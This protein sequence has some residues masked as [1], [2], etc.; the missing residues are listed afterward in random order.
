MLQICPKAKVVA[1]MVALKF[2]S[3]Q[4]G[5]EFPQI[6]AK[7]GDIID[8]GDKHLTII[9]APNLHWPD[10]TYTYLQE[11]QILF[12]CDSFGAH[13]CHEAMYDDLVGDY[14]DAFQYY[15]DVILKP[16]SSHFL[17][18]IDKIRDLPI[19]TICTGHG[20]I[21]RTYS[22]NIVAKT[23]QLCR[24]YLANYPEKNRILLAYV[25]AYGFTK[26]IAEKIK[27]GMAEVPEVTVD[28]C[29]I[30]QM[31]AA[32]LA[33]KVAKASAY[34]LGSPTINQNMLPQL[35]NVFASMTPI[36]EKD[37]QA[38]CFGSYGWSG[39]AE[40]ILTTGI[41]N[42]KLKFSGESLFLKFKPQESDFEMIKNFGKAFALLVVGK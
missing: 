36:R 5:F 21:L 28:F 7:D 26:T 22:K 3:N 40:K 1:S 33:D 20:P 32:T 6:V 31:D 8:L 23:E 30:E 11:E 2:L 15:F 25:S 34:M 27:E 9:N 29:D 12:T 39:E 38:S 17:K 18:A 41:A 14:N 24:E 35:Y 42:M 4:V 37:K 10:S 13:F 19:Q 16:F